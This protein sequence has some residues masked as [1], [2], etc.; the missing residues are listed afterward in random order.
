MSKPK[1]LDL[2]CCQGGA[3]K[4]YSDAGFDVVGVDI[5]KQ[6]LYPY[7]FIQSDCVALLWR[8]IRGES[9]QSIQGNWFSLSDFAAIHSSPPCQVHSCLAHLATPG[10]HVDLIPETREALIASGLPYIIENVP[11]APLINPTILCGSMFGLGTQC[12]AQLRRHRLFETSWFIMHSLQ[13]A[14][15]GSSIGVFGD[16]ALDSSKERER[17]R[18]RTISITGSTPQR[19]VG[20]VITVS[21][22]GSPVGAHGPNSG[23]IISIHGGKARDRR[24]IITVTGHGM[25]GES[26]GVLETFPVQAARDAMGCQWMT[27]KGLSQAI[28]PAYTQWIGE[29]LMEH[30]G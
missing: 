13:C 3:A 20:R 14:H 15:Q 11:G 27:M 4:G 26:G 5:N 18:P 24:R 2:Y 21:G 16:H 28:P 12:G 6:P 19:Q 1:L 10:K 23:A 9:T 7:D 30:I 8:L 22:S 29:R 17:Y 25:Q